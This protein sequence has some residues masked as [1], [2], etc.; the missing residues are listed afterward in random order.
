VVQL[1]ATPTVS[2]DKAAA[3]RSLLNARC[4]ASLLNVAFTASGDRATLK[5]YDLKGTIKKAFTFKTVSGTT[6]SGNHD[7]SALPDGK[8]IV[9]LDG[10]TMKLQTATIMIAR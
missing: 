3:Q 9:R 7:L 8:Y 4:K 1:G 5:V 2:H 6:Y 10:G